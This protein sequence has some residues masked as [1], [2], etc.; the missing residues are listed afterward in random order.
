MA[1][2]RFV[3]G[4]GS[5]T[6]FPLWRFWLYVVFFSLVFGAGRFFVQAPSVETTFDSSSVLNHE[7]ILNSSIPDTNNITN[8]PQ[9]ATE[10]TG[11]IATTVSGNTV[12]GSSSSAE[13]AQY[14][15]SSV[16]SIKARKQA[17]RRPLTITF[18]PDSTS[19]TEARLNAI[20]TIVESSAFSSKVTPVVVEWNAGRVE[21]RG[22]MSGRKVSLTVSI[23]SDPENAA[24]FTHELGHVVDI[25]GF[26]K[27]TNGKDISDQ[28][29][30]ISWTNDRTKRQD[31]AIADFV[32]GYALSNQYE[33]FAESFAFYVLY[34]D[35][36]ATRAKKNAFLKAKYDFLRNQVFAG[37][38]FVGTSFSYDVLPGYLW[39]TTRAS[40]NLKK[41]LYYLQILLQ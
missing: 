19:I 30:Q 25:Y 3:F 6:W 31:S 11:T 38:K 16:A 33:D 15:K 23:E 17:E 1:S 22:Q 18:V 34:N 32:S 13:H 7:I 29:Y 4:S 5:K 36:F 24:V 21:P 9:E 8:I 28:F 20:K 26:P 12:S 14:I 37:D 40:L 10:L 35:E 2:S 39:D 41:Y 27:D